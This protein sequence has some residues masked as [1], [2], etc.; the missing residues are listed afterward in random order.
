MVL[1]RHLMVALLA[2]TGAGVIM[3]CISAAQATEK[4]GDT[5]PVTTSSPGGTEDPGIEAVSAKAEIILFSESFEGSW[6]AAPWRVTHP[7]EATDVDW[8]RTDFRS[9]LGSHSIWCAQ[10][11]PEAPGTGGPVPANT[12]SWAIAGPFDLSEARTAYLSFD[13]WLK[14]ELSN[15]VVMWLV[16]TD[17]ES[18]EGSATSTDTNGWKTMSVDLAN[19]GAAGDV[20]G[21]PE[22]WIAFVYASD[23]SNLFEGAYIDNVVLVADVP[24]PGGEGTTYSSKEDFERGTVA[25]T[26][27]DV[28]ALTLSPDWFT[29][30]FIWVPN[31]GDGT[32]SKIDT[33]SGDEVARYR[34]GPE[35]DLAPSA[36]AVDLDGS[37]WVG[38]RGA[39]SVVKV[40]HE[41]AGG[42]VDRNGNGRIDTSSD[43]DGNGDISGAELLAWGA[44]ECVL[45][46]VLLVD[47]AEGTYIPGEEHGGYA[48]NNLQALAIN[49]DGDLWAGVFDSGTYYKVDG[50][51]GE[52]LTSLDVSAEET[53]P[54]GLVIDRRGTMWSSSWPDAWVL[55]ID[56]TTGELTPMALDHGSAGLALDNG[57]HLFVTGFSEG[58]MSRIDLGKE[59]VDG[60]Y[61]VQWQSKG[62]AVTSDGD[63]WVAAAGPAR[64]SRYS[65]DGSFRV[66]IPISN[67]P[68]GVAVDGDGKV[69]VAGLTSFIM[70]IDPAKNQADLQKEIID[71]GGHDVSGDMTGIVARAITTSYGTWTVVHDSDTE[72]A[73]WGTISWKGAEPDGTAISVRVRSSVDQVSWSGWE[74]ATN[75]IALSKTP[76]GRYLQIEAA[77]KQT[78]SDSP[79]RLE[80][81]TVKPAK[82]AAPPDAA[83]DWRPSNP[84]AKQKVQFADTSTG[85]PTSWSWDFGDG[86]SSGLQNPSHTFAAAGSY[87]ISLTVTSADGSD[88]ESQGLAVGTTTGCDLTC[89]VAVPRTAG[90][91]EEA[92]FTAGAVPDNCAEG[93]SYSWLFGDGDTSD[94]QNPGHA[95]DES[96]TY[97]WSMTASA[98][99][100]TC[101]RSGHITIVGDGPQNCSSTYWVPVVSRADGAFD[102]V[103]RSDLGLLGAGEATAAVELRFHGPNG[104]VTRVI[105]VAR[106]AMVNLVDVVGWMSPGVEASGALE[107]CSDGKLIVTS[108]TYSQLADDDPCFKKGSFGTNL[109]GSESGE[110]LSAGETALLS[111]L[112]ET[113][114]FRTNIGLVNTGGQTAT[115]D[116]TLYDGTGVSLASY[117]VELDPAEWQQA[118]RPLKRLAGAEDLDAA[119]AKVSVNSGSG[120]FAYATVADNVTNDSTT[121]S[122]S[123]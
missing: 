99:G 91:G 56:P 70:R 77:L 74:Q 73:A 32:V 83:F 117:S 118:N 104:T 12:V 84:A 34:T 112:R 37:C 14:T 2:V 97:R 16:S 31:S 23:H 98:S 13:L 18:F 33:A 123:R 62:A 38:N 114:A 47:G 66:S 21:F 100:A 53:H 110:G 5:P 64:V 28:D 36:V 111:H 45:Y 85:G 50:A 121:I 52:I 44:D 96:S 94:K 59:E 71:S 41:A 93:V 86:E 24:T 95:Y 82:A 48:R 6:P 103:W 109:D 115:V 122:M 69:W 20:T 11:G 7:P 106:G 92:L 19:W 63:V 65:N 4:T 87:Q 9:S 35:R 17:N 105:S 55:K 119:W 25:G 68:T 89:S 88:T 90:I 116:V 8:G 40:A 30:P 76:V 61:V 49:R 58:L 60:N 51:S 113:S 79:P 81:L 101:I 80:E 29:L 67:A 43:I 27:Y 10:T 57:D 1:N 42:C 75:G 3:P 72:E 26:E 102:S 107:V 39:G 78:S 120:V 108:R 54:F 22:V 46:E 15:D